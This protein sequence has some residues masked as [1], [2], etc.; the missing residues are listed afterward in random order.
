MSCK[1]T[2][3][4]ALANTT[5]LNPPKVNRAKKPAAQYNATQSLI[6][7]PCKVAIQLKTLTP[8]GTAIIIVTVLK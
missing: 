8:V 7:P 3:K 5:P 2:S 4:E 1:P 6:Q